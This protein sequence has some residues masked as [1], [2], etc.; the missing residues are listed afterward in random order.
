MPQSYRIALSNADSDIT[1][2]FRNLGCEVLPIEEKSQ[3]TLEDLQTADALYLNGETDDVAHMNV[4]FAHALGIPVF[5]QGEPESEKVA[6][7]C[8]L[9]AGPED[10]KTH[11]E[12]RSPVEAI[13]SFASIEQ[14]QT[15]I[16]DMVE[17]RGFEDESAQD[18]LLL[19]TEEVG[20]LAKA[21]RKYVGLKSEENRQ[22]R[23]STLESEM[24]D[25][26]IYLL[27]LA[28]LF[29]VSLVDALYEKERENE[30]RTW[31]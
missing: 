15:Y 21:A 2:T 7:V 4:G 10:V 25:V 17:R 30:K 11:L 1:E 19:M 18:V 9:N 8:E 29:E 3:N 22:D 13:R 24:A 26:F 6:Q 20:E 5:C 14:L 16:R 27:Q 23:Y 12:D 31:S 28:N